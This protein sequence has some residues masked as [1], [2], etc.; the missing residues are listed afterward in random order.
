M[1]PEALDDPGST[2][3]TRR[4]WGKPDKGRDPRSGSQ[5]SRV[6]FRSEWWPAGPHRLVL[7]DTG[8]LRHITL[9]IIDIG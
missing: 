9:M 2:W 3:Q 1:G 8:S 7:S 4:R 5:T 6:S